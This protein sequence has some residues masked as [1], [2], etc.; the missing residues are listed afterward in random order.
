MNCHCPR[1]GFLFAAASSDFGQA[2][3]CR[4]CGFSGVL[5]SDHL[6]DFE[7]PEDIRSEIREAD[8]SP[9]AGPH[10]NPS[11]ENFFDIVRA[12]Q[13]KTRV[14]LCVTAKVA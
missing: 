6:A 13:K 12:L 11:T 1:C 14:K 8:G 7:L 10:G 3:A 9:W 2:F 4:Q 5:D